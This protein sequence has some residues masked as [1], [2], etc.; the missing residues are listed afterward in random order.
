M[1]CRAADDWGTRKKRDTLEKEEKQVVAVLPVR[2]RSDTAVEERK[3]DTRRTGVETRQL[4]AYQN[5]GWLDL[6]DN[7]TTITDVELEVTRITMIDIELATDQIA[8]DAK[9]GNSWEKRRREKRLTGEAGTSFDVTEI[10][11]RT[12][13]LVDVVATAIATSSAAIAT[14]TAAIATSPAVITTSLAAS[15]VCNGTVDVLFHQGQDH[16]KAGCIHGHKSFLEGHK[17]LKELLHCY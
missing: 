8:D 14:S 10:D 16:N 4:H 13:S 1:Y 12:G 15:S 3:D 17:A 6:S 5:L 2:R 9:E 7:V 11:A